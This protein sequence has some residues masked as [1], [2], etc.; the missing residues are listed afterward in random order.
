MWTLL[1]KEVRGFFTSITGYLVIILY[2]IANGLIMWV[3]HG[4]SNVLDAGYANI[5]P[6]F[7]LSPWLFLFLVPAVTMRL[8]SDEKRMGTIELLLVRPIS[9]MKIVLSKFFAGWILVVLAILPTVV[10]LISL[11][12]LGNPPGNFDAGAILGSYIGLVFLAAIYTAIGVFAS[13]LSS[14]QII[15]FLI[16]VLLSFIMYAGFNELAGFAFNGSVHHF[17]SSLG[18]SYHYSSI[19]RGVI[20]S[21][22]IIY[23]ISVIVVFL[24][25]TKLV[26]ASRKWR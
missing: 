16:A 2:L 19:S 21:R 7:I 22:N 23:F 18:I 14:N 17:V 10:Y 20:D 11:A 9:E 3:F 25:M 4:N 8:F 13:S 12:K 6:L 24:Y 5:D 1:T 15:A 26:L